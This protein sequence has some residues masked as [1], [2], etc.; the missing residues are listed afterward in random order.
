M[1]DLRDHHINDLVEALGQIN[2]PL[3]DREKPSQ[4][5][6]RLLAVR[7]DDVRRDLA[8]GESRHKKST[9]PLSPARIKRIMAVLDSALNAAVKAKKLDMNP[10]TLVELPRVARVE[11][12]VWTRPRVQRWLAKGHVP[13]PVMVWTP[14]QTG[15]FLDFAADERLYALYDLTAFRG[16]RRAETAGLPWSELDLDEGLLTVSET[17]PDGSRDDPEDPKSEAGSRTVSLDP[18]TVE[19]LRDWQDRQDQERAD[20]GDSWTDSGKVF[21]EPDGTP[22]RPE[23]ISQRFDGLI[24]KYNAIRKGHAKGRTIEQLAQRHWVSEAAVNIALA[25]PL[26]PIRYHD[27]RHGAATLALA[28]DVDMKVVSEILGHSKSSFTSDVYTSVIP[29]VHRAAA[30]AV[31]AVVPRNRATHREADED[32]RG[33]RRARPQP[34]QHQSSDR[35]R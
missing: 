14:K 30:E 11:P 8:P 34:P 13:G 7:A 6:Q 29:E 19:I 2:R 21:T 35:S 32:R 16:L 4:L 3:P 31:A 27:L 28:A 9:K 22:L 24:A 1:S 12:L 20:A 5:L 25:E 33:L 15:A 10:R 17:T 23:W 26:P 18:A